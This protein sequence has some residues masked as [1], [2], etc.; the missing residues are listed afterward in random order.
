[1]F[2]LETTG[3]LA[4]LHTQLHSLHVRLE[5]L[6]TERDVFAEKEKYDKLIEETNLEIDEVISDIMDN[7]IFEG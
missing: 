2:D 7:N 3:N 6:K 5:K 1:M 4:R